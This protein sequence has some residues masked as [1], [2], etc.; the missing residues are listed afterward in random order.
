MVLAGIILLSL[1]F[2]VVTL[3]LSM[4]SPPVVDDYGRLSSSSSSSSSSPAAAHSESTTNDNATFSPSSAGDAEGGYYDCSV[5]WLRMPKTASTSVTRAFIRPMMSVPD[6]FTNVMNGPNTCVL[7]RGGCRSSW[8]E[9]G[10][11]GGEEGEGKEQRPTPPRCL[12]K[13]GGGK[14][15]PTTH[16][17]EFDT[18]T[19]ALDFGP[20]GPRRRRRGRTK[21]EGAGGSRRDDRV[22]SVHRQGASGPALNTHVGLDASLFGWILPDRP[23][24]FS[25]FRDPVGR[26]LSSFHYGVTYGGGLPG[27]VAKCELPLRSSSPSSS[28]NNDDNATLADWQAGVANA[29]KIATA[30]NDTSVYQGLLRDY[31]ASCRDAADNAYVQFLDPRTKDLRLAL[32]NLERYVIVGL[33]S[34]VDVSLGRFRDVALRSCA[35]HP[36]YRALERVLS[37]SLAVNGDGYWRKSVTR[38]VVASGSPRRDGLSAADDESRDYGAVVEP[39]EL[40]SPDVKTFDE[41]LQ[42][43]VRKMTE[44]DET[45]YKRALELYYYQAHL[46]I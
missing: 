15:G 34:D 8:G 46:G 26:L 19:S 24:V 7:G 37:R 10:G 5:Y 21:G 38:V 42:K 39:V 40:A 32:Y 1:S 27:E 31:L 14:Q 20:D 45:I 16:C 11:G 18:R 9:E 12:P 13:K 36:K 25:T 22:R 23:M 43:L 29:R 41:D 6:L 2:Q 3:C 33:Q 44:G 28:N 17:Y 4:S 30:D 35:G